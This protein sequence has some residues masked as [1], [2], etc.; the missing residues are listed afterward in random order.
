MLAIIKTLK[1]WYFHL[2]GVQFLVYT[3]YHTFEYFK[4][5]KDLSCHQIHWANTLV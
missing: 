3:D 1:K 4:N 2:F 5:Q